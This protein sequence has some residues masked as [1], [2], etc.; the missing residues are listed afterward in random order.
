[1]VVMTYELYY[2]A[3][4]NIKKTFHEATFYYI[5]I[6]KEFSI[7]KIM[8]HIVIFKDILTE[9]C[10]DELMLGSCGCCFVQLHQLL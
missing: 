8:L 2:R 1:M 6:F 3:Q 9:L 7:F 4:M 10:R 5:I